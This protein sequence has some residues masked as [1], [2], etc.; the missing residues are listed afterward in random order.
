LSLIVGHLKEEAVILELTER[1]MCLGL[2][3]GGEVMKTGQ[4]DLV[5]RVNQ[6]ETFVSKIG[7]LCSCVRLQKTFISLIQM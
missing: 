2:V 4:K 5:E 1:G 7:I 6:E 3:A